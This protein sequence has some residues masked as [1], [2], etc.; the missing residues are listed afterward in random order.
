MKGSV[1]TLL[2]RCLLGLR[3][4]VRFNGIE[5]VERL[6]NI[7][8]E[9]GGILFLPNHPALV[10][11]MILTAHLYPRFQVHTLADQDRVSARGVAW[12]TKRLN[13]M[14]MPDPMVH[15][16][17]AIPEVERVIQRCID[18]LKQ[19]ENWMLYPA[20]RI[21]RSRF[22]DL[23]GNSAVESI[24][25]EYPEARVVL[26]RTKGLWGSSFGR[27][28]GQSPDLLPLVL[29][30]LKS[31]LGSL[32]LLIPK[33][34]V[35]ITLQE[36]PDLPRREGRSVL[37]RALE[38][39]YNEDAPPARYVPYT[40]WEWGGVRDL[41]EVALRQVVGDLSLVN[42]EIRRQVL[43]FLQ[44]LSGRET[45]HAEEQLARDLGLDS[46]ARMEL[47]TWIEQTFGFE[48]KDIESL[49]SVGDCL[50]A[51]SG[52]L[53]ESG[54]DVKTMDSAW[55]EESQIGLKEGRNLLSAFLEKANSCPKQIVLADGGGVKS[56]ENIM[57]GILALR[58]H[59]AKLEG[60]YI[61]I[62]L[63]ASTGAA[64][65]MMA[66]LFA[67]KIPVMINWTVGSRNLSHALD[68]LKI[69]HVLTAS[70]LLSKLETQGLDLG[71]LRRRF[72]P[73][74]EITKKLTRFEKLFALVQAKTGIHEL[75]RTKVHKT[76][77]V[78]FTSGSESLPKAVPLTHENLLTNVK[79]LASLF[80]FKSNERMIGFLPPFHSFGLTG[81]VLLPLLSGLPVVYHPNPLDSAYLSKLIYE[82]RVT[83]LVGTPTFLGNIVRVSTQ[84]SLQS[85]RYVVAGAEK[86][87]QALFDVLA[88]QWPQLE[89][90]EGYGITECSPVVS[91]NRPGRAVHGSI[92]QVLP[93]VEYAIQD[94]ESGQRVESGRQ[95]LLLVRGPSIFK[96]YLKHDGPSP[97]VEFEG[98]PWYRTGDL[99]MEDQRGILHF[100]GRL[101]RFVKLGGEMVSLPAVEEALLNAYGREDEAVLAVEATS[102]E[103]APELVL[104]TLLDLKREGVNDV[105]RKAGLSSLHFI[106][107]IRQ[108][109]AIP[110]LGTGKT[111]YRA[112][113]AML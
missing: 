40:P 1:I 75:H 56:Y 19:G 112:L 52:Q 44:Q 30:G 87:P 12:L 29:K 89:V 100:K 24:L 33:R 71:A 111:D 41:P 22:E 46:L 31:M 80:E 76:A 64:T 88:S 102:D 81:T 67:G 96:G 65:L 74:E 14:P 113:K 78:L 101:K 107:Q 59:I 86:C 15:G 6:E 42:D 35:E 85:L 36:T 57:T 55:F 51:A 94:V 38:T 11:P 70:P 10:D 39:F 91:A 83:L 4:R 99:V 104:F 97:F 58:P 93:S 73:V 32:F 108:I 8:K 105:L 7:D 103:T 50:L 92:G 53:Q 2:G 82:A 106:K 34:E 72:L 63:P 109:E 21:Y 45:V 23:G 60:V 26:V 90:L 16:A 61:G 48:I 20:G 28:S 110:L 68:L 25:A 27:A 9:K 43:A 5:T 54:A 95:G 84:A 37:N 47:Q 62:M 66:C 49:V 77:V 13:V 3:Y 69:K 79:D 17:A 18:G 98:N